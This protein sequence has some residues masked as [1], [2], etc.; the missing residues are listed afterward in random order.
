[1]NVL[2]SRAL[3]ATPL[4]HSA[5]TVTITDLV[6]E[7]EL[8]HVFCN[9]CPKAI[10][11][12]YSFPVPLDSAFMGMEATLAGEH[13]IAKILP[14]K[15]ASERYDDAITDG[16]S[17]VLLERIE[18]GMLCVNLGNLN[19]GE[20]GEI[21]LRFAAPLRCAGGT[22]R[23]SLPLVHRPR[24][25][26]SGLD[27]LV[28]PRN[29]FAVEHPLEAVIRVR[30]LLS[31]V[32]VSCAS[33]AARFST[34]D[35]GL[36]LRL[37]QAMLDRDLVLVFE[38]PAHFAGHAHLV[39]DG[40]AAVG[41]LGFNVPVSLRNSG[42]CDL[43]LVMDGSG[44]MTGDAI[45]QSRAALAA[46][47]G[48]LGDEDRIQVLRFGSKTVPLFR[49]PLKASA[50]VRDAMA[51]LSGTIDSSLGG[52]E[53]GDALTQA[54]TSLAGLQAHTD[55]RRAVILVTDGAV[56]PNELEHAKA[57]ASKYN[58]RIFVVAV[59]SSAGADVLAPLATDTN[60][61]IE[62]A[63]P[64]ESIDEV[65]LR[66]L[67]RAREFAPV[68]VEVDWGHP[69]ANPLPI[70]PVYAG[71][72][73][74]AIAMLSD[75]R[76]L[77]PEIRI[78]GSRFQRSF[79][80]DKAEDAPALRALAGHSAWLSAPEEG[81]EALA[82]RYGLVTDETSAVLVKVRADAQKIEGLPMIVPVAHMEP[83]GMVASYR[84]H[85]PV[86][87]ELPS[88][89]SSGVMACLRGTTA[90]DMGIPAF[91]RKLPDDPANISESRSLHPRGKR[92]T[93]SVSPPIALDPETLRTLANAL[94]RLLFDEKDGEVTV[95]NLLALIDP[96]LRDQV[97][98]YIAAKCPKGIDYQSAVK[99][100]KRLLK[101][102]GIAL[103]DDQEA[104]FAVMTQTTKT[105]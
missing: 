41:V 102:T 73:V 91:L 52:T 37:N 47:A 31:N 39:C 54:T 26:C 98:A 34:D 67:Q 25:G 14:S 56:Q 33:H 78:G 4:S 63:V 38:L 28:E 5:L 104:K 40:D 51:E 21:T 58:I 79:R 69:G 11:A 87:L 9:D 99:L 44:S 70:A 77:E 20:D 45:A 1:M 95:D 43:C 61:V 3:N 86:A 23:F 76:S 71:D 84:D 7:Y 55:R 103:S 66:Q 29:D 72:A 64:A 101:S 92:A 85:L 96:A 36:Q 15:H 46:V 8:R 10:E 50:R 53:I 100:M 83:E 60:G 35:T 89:A 27:E 32:P 17:A 19:P 65:V 80:L 74:T 97:A 30:G 22:A 42:P 88:Y 49:R 62:R 13:L 93:R 57:R 59:G 94:A 68:A 2:Q 24:Y 81:K 16:N 75:Q 48:M 82:M 12:V 105:R 90:W 6:A 18:P